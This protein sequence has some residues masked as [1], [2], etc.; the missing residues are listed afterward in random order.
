MA[1]RKRRVSADGFEREAVDRI[2]TGGMTIIAVAGEP[3]LHETALRRRIARFGD[4]AAADAHADDAVPGRPGARDCAPQARAAPRRDGARHLEDG[5]ARHRPRTMAYMARF[6][7]GPAGDLP[8]HRRASRHLA[9]QDDVPGDGGVGEPSLRLA[10]PSGQPSGLREPRASREDP[11]RSR[12]HRRNPRAA[13]QA[14]RAP[15]P[16]PEDRP[17]PRRA[18]HGPGGSSRAGRAAPAH[19]NCGQPPLP[20]D[21]PEQDRP[22]R[23]RIRIRAR[24][25]LVH[26]SDLHPDRRGLAPPRRPDR[27]ARPQGR[28]LG[29]ARDLARRD[30]RRGPAHGHREAAL[31]FRAHPTLGSRRPWRRGN[32]PLDEPPRSSPG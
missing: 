6:S 5:R 29:H 20:S 7:A 11:G 9:G 19:A 30:R 17:A 18:A 10:I 32:N 12:R 28:G 31:S 22:E 1:E 26:R 15:Q 21:R 3:G 8:A 25:G 4:G 16:W 2:R 24:P 13:P 23:R 27:H 14:R